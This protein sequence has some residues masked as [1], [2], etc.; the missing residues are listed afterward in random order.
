MSPALPAEVP[1]E[2]PPPVTPPGP[3]AVPD[4]GSDEVVWHPGMG[5]ATYGRLL[6]LLFDPAPERPA[7]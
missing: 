1:G 2:T 3:V 7:A 4:D 6:R 5:R